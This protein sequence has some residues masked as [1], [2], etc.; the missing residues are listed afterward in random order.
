[1]GSSSIA[2]E[3]CKVRLSTDPH[4]SALCKHCIGA[5]IPRTLP[6]SA[7]KLR[8]GAPRG[9]GACSPVV[10]PAALHP[11]LFQA[12][13]R[14]V[15]VLSA[16]MKSSSG[17]WVLPLWRRFVW[18]HRR[19]VEHVEAALGPR[20]GEGAILPPIP[21]VSKVPAKTPLQHLDPAGL[22]GNVAVPLAHHKAT[23]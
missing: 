17:Q 4:L 18:G 2:S 1:M 3:A 21:A 5:M 20:A 13:Q 10:H 7:W 12:I 22:C 9:A 16:E 23:L 15:H 6:A 19:E 14:L 8:S 11:L